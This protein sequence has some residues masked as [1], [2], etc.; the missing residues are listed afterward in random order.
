MAIKSGTTAITVALP[1]LAPP[2]ATCSLPFMLLLAAPR[3]A[4]QM[5]WAALWAAFGPQFDNSYAPWAAQLIRVLGPTTG[6]IV[7]PMV[8]VLSDSCRSTYGRRRPYILGGTVA[9]IVVWLLM[10]VVSSVIQAADDKKA[11]ADKLSGVAI[12]LY[13]LMG[14][15]VNTVQAP[16][17]LL[18]ADFAGDHQVTAFSLAQAFSIIGSLLVSGFI[19]LYGPASNVTIQILFMLILA[20]VVTVLPV[21]LYVSETPHVPE[22]VISRRQELKRGVVAFY[23][24]LKYLPRVLAVYCVCFVLAMLGY[25]SYTGNKNQFFGVLFYDGIAADAD[26]CGTHCT[27]AQL[28]YNNGTQFASGTV[29]TLHSLLGLL[30]L[31]VLPTLVRTFGV[32]RVFTYAMVPQMTLLLAFVRVKELNA[33]S[34]ILSSITQNTLFTMGIPVVLHV[35]GYGEANGLGLFAGAL[36]SANCLGQFLTFALGPLLSWMGATPELPIMFDIRMRS[37]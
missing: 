17:A 3:L 1:E 12:V 24:G 10:V 36:N 6:L 20:L 11:A 35:I 25:A 22:V 28:R 37:L 21:L 5:A 31:A 34:A 19:A 4:I 23:D 13:F 2:L 9:S 27:D 26:K 29:D 33:A 8:S 30:Y 15:A 14:V 7:Y 18:I 16:A 32:R